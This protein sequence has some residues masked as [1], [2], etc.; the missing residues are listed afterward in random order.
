M[1]GGSVVIIGHRFPPHLRHLE[2]AG[3]YNVGLL[4][5]R[6]DDVG[7]Q[8]LRRWRDQC[9]EWCY[10]RA[11]ADRYADQKYL[12]DWPMRFPGVVVLQNEGA[13]LAPWNVVNYSLRVEKGQILV[14]SQPLVFFH[15]HGLKQ[16]RRWLYDSGLAGYEAH[17]GS[18]LRKQIYAP[19]IREL[20]EVKSSL[21]LNQDSLPMNSIRGDNRAGVLRTVGRRIKRPLSLVNKLLRRQCLVIVGER[22]V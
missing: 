17:P 13:G 22:I 3:V 15:F 14:D 19:Y 7:L 2:V 11:E 21:S 18:V 4:S 10:D 5:F 9:L 1:A 8:C 16:V 12:D 6:R 20:N